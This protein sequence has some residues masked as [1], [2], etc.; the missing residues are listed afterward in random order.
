MKKHI[1]E[2]KVTDDWQARV[3][4]QNMENGKWFFKYYAMESEAKTF[5]RLN[6]KHYKGC[7]ACSPQNKDGIELSDD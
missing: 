3:L 4:C 6:R 5:Y 2:L 1:P 7:R